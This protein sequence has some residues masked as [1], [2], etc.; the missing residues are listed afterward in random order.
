MRWNITPELLRTVAGAPVSKTVTDGLVQYLPEY[1]EKYGLNTQLEL[2]H[3]LA[4]A[5]H[6]SDHFRTLTEYASGAAYEGRK[7]LGN[8]YPGDG[9][10]YKGR[11]IFQLTGRANYTAMSK[12]LGVDLVNNP[13]LAATPEISV[14]TALEYW[15]SRNLSKW[16]KEDNVEQ[17]TKLINGGYNGLKARR[18]HLQRAKRAMTLLE[19][20]PKVE[21]PKT[22]LPQRPEP[23]VTTLPTPLP[24]FVA[25]DLQNKDT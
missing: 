15:K 8:I 24:T 3:F 19:T 21:K 10:R 5:A 13:G 18:I 16:A 17:V 14:Q 11:G 23:R 7:D 2:T 1:L 12:K 4:Q 9:R 20:R 25:I 6:E 22:D